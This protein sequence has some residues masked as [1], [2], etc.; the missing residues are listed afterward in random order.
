MSHRRRWSELH[1]D[2]DAN[3]GLGRHV[4]AHVDA[5]RCRDRDAD[6]Y[7]YAHAYTHTDCHLHTHGGRNQ[8]AHR[9][10]DQHRHRDEHGDAI[11]YGYVYE[12]ALAHLDAQCPAVSAAPALSSSI[13]WTE[14]SG[15]RRATV[16]DRQY[17]LV[18]GFD[19][20][21]QSPSLWWLTQSPGAYVPVVGGSASNSYVLDN[22]AHT[23][24]L[25][26]D[27]TSTPQAVCFED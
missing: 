7:A 6:A 20:N 14:A 13:T 27:D 12:Y 5:R 1:A 17:H 22:T 21:Q 3:G 25:L 2:A 15:A 24:T 19:P 4:N 10:R 23:V 26:L 18:L 9:H 16:G 11:P 8:D